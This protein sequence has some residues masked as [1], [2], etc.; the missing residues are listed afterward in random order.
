MLI[1]NQNHPF[2]RTLEQE[3]I[4]RWQAGSIA[5][6]DRLNFSVRALRAEGDFYAAEQQSKTMFT[7]LAELMALPKAHLPE[8]LIPVRNDRQNLTRAI[9]CYQEEFSYAL[10]HHPTLKTLRSSIATLQQTKY[11]PIR[12]IGV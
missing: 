6:A 10:K 12:Q 4:I 8:K 9:P 7:V 1:A 5:E 2:N 11:S 3:S